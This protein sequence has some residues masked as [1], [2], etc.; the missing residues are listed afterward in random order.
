MY[1]TST[2]RNYGRNNYG[3]LCISA[4]QNWIDLL[5]EEGEKLQ[6]HSFI[7]NCT[8]FNTKAM[9]IRNVYQTFQLNTFSRYSVSAWD[10]Q[11]LKNA[12]LQ[13]SVLSYQGK[14]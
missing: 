14:K 7:E 5:Y 13:S 8:Y 10:R 1:L 9:G 12:M 2:V 4:P 3:G 11:E 6:E